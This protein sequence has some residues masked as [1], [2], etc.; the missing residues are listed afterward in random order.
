M[1]RD[2]AHED[3]LAMA[4]RHVLEGEVRVARQEEIVATLRRHGHEAAARRGEAVL[5]QMRRALDL[6]RRHLAFE[7]DKQS[8]HKRV[9]EDP[10][11]QG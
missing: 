10:Q 11:R 5:E 1:V 4:Q 9:L 2:E 7:L 3:M 8:R 6:G